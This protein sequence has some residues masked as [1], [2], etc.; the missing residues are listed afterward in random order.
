M[1]LDIVVGQK[2]QV[3]L[4]MLDR[5]PFITDLPVWYDAIGVAR[6][7]QFVGGC[8]Y[9]EYRPCAGGGQLQMWAAGHNWLSRRVIETMLGFPFNVIGC[10]RVTAMTAKG[11][12]PSRALL[13]RLGFVE[14]GKLRR[15]FDTRQDL[16][17]YGLLRSECGW[18]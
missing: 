9:S 5:L 18:V 7:G 14:E 17:L 2:E 13:E 10:H 11:N 3:A 16:I 1:P 8:L 6:D 15:G 4:W 12:K